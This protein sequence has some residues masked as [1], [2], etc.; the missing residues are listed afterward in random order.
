MKRE[1]AALP[2]S[3]GQPRRWLGLERQGQETL[4]LTVHSSFQPPCPLQRLRETET[5]VYGVRAVPVTGITQ[6]NVNCSRGRGN[7]PG[8]VDPLGF[9]S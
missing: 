3:E 6:G 5:A 4:I 9:L 7:H 1:K 2:V 8:I